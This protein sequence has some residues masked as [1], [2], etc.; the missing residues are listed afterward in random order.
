MAAPIRHHAVPRCQALSGVRARRRTH[1]RAHARAI[2]AAAASASHKTPTAQQSIQEAST[3]EHLAAASNLLVLPDEINSQQSHLKQHIHQIKRQAAATR[4]LVKA[5]KLSRASAQDG[6]EYCSKL[7][8][9]ARAAALPSTATEDDAA[10][11][12]RCATALHAIASL[13][14][15]GNHNLSDHVLEYASQLAV[16]VDAHVKS[17]PLSL[18]TQTRWACE[19]LGVDA[20]PE[21]ITFVASQAPFHVSVGELQD[22]LD[23]QLLADAIPFAKEMLVTRSGTKVLERRSTCWM[24]DEDVGGLAYSGKIMLPKPFV[25]EVAELRDALHATY[26]FYSDCC[27]INLY[28]DGSCACRWHF[29]PEHGEA[30]DVPRAKWDARQ[31]V[32]SVGASR[33]F[34]FRPRRMSGDP[35]PQMKDEDV[36]QFVVREGDVVW[37][38]DDCQDAWEHAVLKD[39]DGCVEAGPR[40]SIVFKSALIQPGG[41]KGHP[42]NKAG[43]R[44]ERARRRD[45]GKQVPKG[46]NKRR[47]RA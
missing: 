5:V 2:L 6:Q 19:C 26:G 14:A 24:A 16:R 23:V 33:R 31:A 11:A 43:S 36:H 46:K 37:M 29:D 44:R 20:T 10:D 45:A 9:F 1:T 47:T 15:Y 17:L 40:I 22:A 34:V 13:V 12:A 28:A 35:S 3:L 27:L 18:A 42:L 8:R 21:A 32:V 30:L 39:D 38:Y 41:G 7:A 4:S 25:R